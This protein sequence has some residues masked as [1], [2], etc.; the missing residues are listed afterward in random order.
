[1]TIEKVPKE[2]QHNRYLNR[3]GKYGGKDKN[4]RPARIIVQCSQCGQP[5]SLQPNELKN[6]KHKFCSHKC[7][8]EW[9]SKNRRAEKS[10]RWAGG[11]R[12]NG[13]GY[14][15]IRL[16]PDD[17]YYPMMSVRHYVREHRLVMAKH[18]ERCLLPWEVVHHI[19]GIKDDNR[20]E[21]LKLLDGNGN[22]NTFLDKWCNKLM[23]ENKKLKAEI[24]RLKK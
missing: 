9:W 15:E 21:N 18:L 12:N 11:R 17:F 20:L 23:K 10:P 22:H 7:Y 13:Q 8:S 4:K 14:I 24:A 19:N 16:Q 3:S 1:M 5:I 6:R 2:Y